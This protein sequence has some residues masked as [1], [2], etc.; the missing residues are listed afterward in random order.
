MGKIGKMVGACFTAF[1]SNE[2]FVIFGMFP[3]AKDPF[4]NG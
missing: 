4:F 2:L 3:Y 1:L